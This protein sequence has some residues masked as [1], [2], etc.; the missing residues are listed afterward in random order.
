MLDAV[1]IY[2]RNNMTGFI[3]AGKVGTSLGK[4]FAVNGLSVSGYFSRSSDSAKAAADFTES[5]CFEN[6]QQLVKESDTIFI[7][8]PDSE[9]SAVYR[10][11][12]KYDI[13]GKTI[14]HCS[15]SLSAAEVF[16]DINKRGAFGCSV[17]PL[18]P[19]SDRFG[20]YKELGKAFF[21]IEG[22]ETPVRIWH[23]ILRNIGN[24]VKIISGKR[25][26][27]YHAA[28]AVMSNL[29]CALAAQST[30]LMAKC[31]FSENE[32]LSALK[33]LAMSNL[34]HILSSGACNALTGP[35]ERNDV[36]TV[37]KHIDCFDNEIDRN[38]YIS[39]SC[40]LVGLAEK[41]HPERDNSE[42]KELLKS[43]K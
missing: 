42:M 21:C 41:R 8:V 28:C 20:T 4:Y 7:T 32:A 16:S 19:V 40:K 33:P 30:E 24:E 17:H 29:V 14:C 27:E 25:K 12:C 6:T 9:I 35:V 38:M 3:G 5:R 2:R 23:D 18:F 34:E 10:Q 31:G 22:D 43:N 1:L 36:S 37:K 13:N 39:A 11:I 15:G 26:K